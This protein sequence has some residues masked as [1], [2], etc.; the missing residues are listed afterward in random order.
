[1]SFA[2]AY[3]RPARRAKV[4][5]DGRQRPIDRNLRA[6]IMHR[7]K[8]ARRAGDLTRAAVDVLEALLFQF[9]NLSD[10]RCIPGYARLAD[11]AGCA[12]RTV[13]RCLPDLEAAGLITWSH[14]IRRV[15]ERVA[16]LGAGL[17]AM[18]WR[19][20][21]SSNC[22]AFPDTG[23]FD[24]GTEIQIHSLDSPAPAPELLPAIAD[25]LARLARH[26]GAPTAQLRHAE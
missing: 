17:W 11:A 9:A 23:H 6:R 7:A 24:R 4:F 18:V 3:A 20:V 14:R 25:A 15:R 5:T 26:I 2:N 8:A 13:G 10:G 21:R 12:E 1:M 22:Y 19:V 16:G